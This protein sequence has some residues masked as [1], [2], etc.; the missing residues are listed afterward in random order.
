MNWAIAQQLQNGKFLIEAML[1]QDGF[2]VTYKALHRH[3]HIPVIIKT[4]DQFF[5]YH[6]EYQEYLNR[7]IQE[8]HILAQLAQDGHP[9]LV[10]VLDLFVEADHY[11][12]VTEY[13]Q[14][15]NLSA[16]VKQQ[17]ALPET[18][19][20]KY[21]EQVAQ[22]LTVV[23]QAGIVHWNV[24]PENLILRPNGKVVLNDFTASG[25][26]VKATASK[27]LGS[28]PFAPYEK[29][30]EGNRQPTVDI[31]S[32]SG[33]LYY[34]IAGKLPTNSLA[35]KINNEEL[36]PPQKLASV[37]YAV[38]EA[39]VQ[40]MELEPKNRPQ[41]MQEWLSLLTNTQQEDDL[42][43]DRGINYTTLRDFLAAGKWQEADRETWR[44]MSKIANPDTNDW[45][46]PENLD[47]FSC[48]DLYT[49]DQ[50]WRKY[51]K[52]RFGFSIQKQRYQSLG[53]KQEC[54]REIWAKFSD[55]VGWRENDRW[56]SEKELTYNLSA[57]S[58]H[59]PSTPSGWVYL[60]GHLYNRLETAAFM[61]M[62]IELFYQKIGRI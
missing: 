10:R 16:R 43:S 49:I 50:L 23:H 7:F 25:R 36:I 28:C 30:I 59:L 6:P 56:L 52:K 38:N 13:V 5:R 45:L 1:Q 29:I 35:R 57:P 41:S 31:Y 12:L 33:T 39:I 62:A 22:A 42:S 2:G 60:I 54:N 44:I 53:G 19:A 18:E 58:G 3:L 40:G 48:L 27:P 4:T 61:K 14:G 21:I 15:E 20:I 9:N 47:N 32:L 8:A 26:I 51:S 11:C 55:T 46:K 37:S 24:I 34:L 17:G